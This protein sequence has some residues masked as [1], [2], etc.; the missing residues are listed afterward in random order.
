MVG[1]TNPP[2]TLRV[3][4]RFLINAEGTSTGHENCYDPRPALQKSA[5][6]KSPDQGDSSATGNIVDE[7]SEESFP[8]SDPPAFGPITGVG[9]QSRG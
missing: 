7:A 8:A 9:H 1:I 3:I 6:E 4:D 5:L 2:A